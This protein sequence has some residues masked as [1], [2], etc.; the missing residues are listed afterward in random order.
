MSEL[1]YTEGFIADIAQIRFESKRNEIK[2]HVDLLS[3]F[4]E[5][6]ASTLPRPLV[7]QHGTTVRKLVVSPFL[8]VY[9]YREEEDVVY[10]LGL[11]YQRSAW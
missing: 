11:I 5:L 9:E 8:I 10:L 4:P 1:I 6:G 7:E 2:R 3:G